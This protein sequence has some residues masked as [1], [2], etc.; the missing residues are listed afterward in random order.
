MKPWRRNLEM[1]AG[2]KLEDRGKTLALQA[3]GQRP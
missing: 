3:A 1:P 2:K